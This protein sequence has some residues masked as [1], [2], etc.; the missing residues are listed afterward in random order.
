MSDLKSK[1]FVDYYEILG[2]GTDSSLTDIRKSFIKLA[3][4][5][6]P[7]AGGSNEEMQILNNAYKT[8]ADE[9]SRKAYNM[10]HSFN[11]GLGSSSYDYQSLAD[12]GQKDEDLDDEFVDFYLDSVWAEF[13]ETS[14]PSGLVSRFKTLF[15]R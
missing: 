10:V 8:L 4:L 7:D 11:T 5:R 15:R 6:H 12:I 3:K 13:S 9:Y 14:K 1:E 2:V